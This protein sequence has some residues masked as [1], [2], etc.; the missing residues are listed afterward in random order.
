MVGTF[1]QPF[2]CV[3]SGPKGVERHCFM[4]PLS[5][6]KQLG[7]ASP[8]QCAT[9]Q[10]GQTNNPSKETGLDASHYTRI[11]PRGGEKFFL[12]TSSFIG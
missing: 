1:S 12:L 11:S 5:W 6:D 9:G 2:A 8:L 4:K 7:L 10:S 3:A